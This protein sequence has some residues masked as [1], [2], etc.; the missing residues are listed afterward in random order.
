[1]ASFESLKLAKLSPDNHFLGISVTSCIRWPHRQFVFRLI[2][3]LHLQEEKPG[4]KCRAQKMTSDE[5]R[6][7]LNSI[8]DDQTANRA[9]AEEM[10]LRLGTVE[11]QHSSTNMRIQ[12]IEHEVESMAAQVVEK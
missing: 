7:L 3:S 10:A 8:R 12:R 1:M 5:Q 9:A 4:K 6:D 2:I 11:K